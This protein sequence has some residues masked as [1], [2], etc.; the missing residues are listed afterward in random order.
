MNVRTLNLC[1]AH[2]SIGMLYEIAKTVAETDSINEGYAYCS[3]YTFEA[4]QH[5]L[6]MVRER[7]N[8]ESYVTVA[9]RIYATILETQELREG[10]IL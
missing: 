6:E 8:D 1:E 7:K 4:F 2:K 9:L 5:E 10:K 3:N